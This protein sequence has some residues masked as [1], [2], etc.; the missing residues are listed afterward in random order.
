MHIYIYTYAEEKP[1]TVHSVVSIGTRL[2][3]ERSGVR[4]PAEARGGYL[5]HNVQTVSG[6]N[7]CGGT[8]VR[9]EAD[10]THTLSNVEIENDWSCTYTAPPCHR[11]PCSDTI[12]YCIQCHLVVTLT[13]RTVE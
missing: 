4:I 1:C 5:L 11:D 9:G 12:L 13:D 6:A 7:P 3:A 2:W 10:N 8:A